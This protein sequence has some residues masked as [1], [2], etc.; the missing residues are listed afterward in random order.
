MKS[1]SSSC[2][3]S[4]STP[5]A[6]A[7]RPSLR[8]RSRPGLVGSTPTIQRGSM[9]SLRSSLYI[10][11]V[12]MLPGPTMAAVF[13]LTSLLEGHGQGGEAAD[14]GADLVAGG[15]R[16]ERPERARQDHLAGAQRVAEASGLHR[17]P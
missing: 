4:Q 11:S 12:P 16:H 3:S 10:R 6:V 5:S 14:L 17:Q 7:S 8:A 13:L 2:L 1:G 15:E 9:W